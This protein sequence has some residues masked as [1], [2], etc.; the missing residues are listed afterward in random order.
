MHA[1]RARCAVALGLVLASVTGPGGCFGRSPDSRFYV[2]TPVPPPG[3]AAA[4]AGNRELAVSVGPVTLPSYL[5]RPQIVTR[6]AGGEV[7]VAEFDRWADI[8]TEAVPRVLA[9][10]VALRLGSDRV[11]AYPVAPRDRYRVLIAIGR[12]DGS[13]GTAVVLEAY[14]QVLNAAGEEVAARR[15]AITDRVDDAGYAALVAAMSR[16]LGVLAG[17][18]ATVLA[19]L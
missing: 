14:W 7:D 6:R 5:D 1:D 13:L 19:R 18:V 10:D 16:A 8:L 9:E 15:S 3:A 12:F 11:A 4:G 17:D 2:L